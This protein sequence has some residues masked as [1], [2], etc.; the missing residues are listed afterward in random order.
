MKE[1]SEKD[2][3]VRIPAKKG[4]GGN[5]T[6]PAQV[7]RIPSLVNHFVMNLPATAIEF[8]GTSIKGPSNSDAFCGLY[9]GQEGLFKPQTDKEL[10]MIHVYCFQNPVEA[11]EAIVGAVRKVLG[12]EIAACDLSIHD[13]RNVSPNK[14]CSSP[15]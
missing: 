3:E 8:L 5:I 9:Q 14:V 13:V 12:F 1:W 11:N 10:P 6:T 4:R 15:F 2:K 7:Y